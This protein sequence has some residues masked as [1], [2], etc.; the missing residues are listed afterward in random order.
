MKI[1]QLLKLFALT[2]CLFAPASHALTHNGEATVRIITP[3]DISLGNDGLRFGAI[4]PDPASPGTI[5][6]SAVDG[7]E[8][9]VNV[10]CAASDRGAASYYLAGESGKAVNISVSASVSLSGIE[11]SNFGHSMTSTLVANVASLAWRQSLF[12]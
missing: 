6:I 2:G 8:T 3:L 11:G 9:C 10:V 7:S 12:Q 1:I 5:T 4:V